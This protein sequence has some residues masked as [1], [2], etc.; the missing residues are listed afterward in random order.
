MAR[1]LSL[2]FSCRS[3]HCAVNKIHNSLANNLIK[4]GHSVT[5]LY[6]S[7]DKSDISDKNESEIVNFK[8]SR[9]AAKGK[10]IIGS[11]FLRRRLAKYIVDM[12]FD[13]I[14]CDGLTSLYH[15]SILSSSIS[16]PSVLSVCHGYTN[17]KETIKRHL[18]NILSK[19][20]CR[21][22]AVSPPLRTYL[23]ELS[24]GATCV[25]TKSINNALD[26]QGL[27]KN[28]FTRLEARKMLSVQ[29]NEF[30]I[31]CIGR[32]VRGKRHHDIIE[33]IHRLKNGNSIPLAKVLIIGDGDNKLYLENLI[34]KYSLNEEV[35]IVGSLSDAYRYVRAFDLFVM[36]SEKEGF[37]LVL[38]EAIAGHIPVLCSNI[39]VFSHLIN[40]KK[41]QYP[42]G[43]IDL[44]AKK[45][46][47]I[48]RMDKH[49]LQL[50]S[51]NLYDDVSERFTSQ[52]FFSEYSTLIESLIYKSKV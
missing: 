11:Y 37:G 38:L 32:L 4:E 26:F 19:D 33:A 24:I 50:I 47:K 35:R 40:E 6:L 49:K 39:E 22:V 5:T 52:N 13:C 17:P 51:N 21:L 41:L 42:V 8:A 30:V 7:G 10:K 31:A 12:N 18:R 46:H 3:D 43:N 45:I 29:E 28:Q 15:L 44:L 34:E 2:L 25:N 23:L 20:N 48:Y 14:I 27:E 1:I 16:I 36:P 9:K